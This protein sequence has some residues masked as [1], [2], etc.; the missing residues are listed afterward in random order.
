MSIRE[1]RTPALLYKSIREPESHNLFRLWSLTT[2]GGGL[3]GPLCV[4][5]SREYGSKHC[6]KR[7]KYNIIYKNRIPLCIERRLDRYDS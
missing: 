4:V 2:W 3:L 1:E 5:Y 6:K 7:Y